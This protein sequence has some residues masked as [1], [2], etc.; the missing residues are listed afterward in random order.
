[1]KLEPRPIRSFVGSATLAILAG[2]SNGDTREHDDVEVAEPSPSEL[3][4][5]GVSGRTFGSDLMRYLVAHEGTGQNLMISPVSLQMA[6]TVAAA[7]AR[8][9]TRQQLATALRWGQPARRQLTAEGSL[10]Q[11]LHGGDG[12]T[13]DVA[14]RLWTQSG[15]RLGDD[16][17][18]QMTRAFGDVVAEADFHGAPDDARTTINESVS[19]QT[20]GRIE[21]L[22]PSGSVTS[23]TRAVITNA[24]Y[25]KGAWLEEF[26]PDLTYRAPFH[27][28]D[29][30]TVE[31]S[32]MVD[33]RDLRYGEVDGL[34]LVELPYR[35]EAVSMLCI[36]PPKEGVREAVE[37]LDVAEW[38]RF[39]AALS[40]QEIDLVLPRFGFAA[41]YPMID[42]LRALG[43]RHAFD[44]ASAD[45]SALTEEAD[46]FIDGVH[47]KTFV[48][49]NEEG[50]EA[51]AATGI[52]VGVTSVARRPMFRADRPFLFAIRHVESGALLFL[53]LVADPS[54][55]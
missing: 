13:L 33:K 42:A 26:D 55:A 6:L 47:H 12:Y 50:T 52:T 10:A 18:E 22:L 11:R 44:P 29:G 37:R 9:D 36:L 32:L 5:A 43:V 30:S 27:R 7:G 23:N 20:R 1:M 17:R 24:V 40:E 28:D 39:D 41:G 35:G 3:S 51:A 54:S 49:V 2:C 46:L 25:F 45:F 53:G 38:E 34:Q 31:V 19:E 8:G 48:E 15:L 16:Y 4:S 21:D 14:N